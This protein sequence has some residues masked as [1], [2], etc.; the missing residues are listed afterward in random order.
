MKFVTVQ[1]CGF[2]PVSTRRMVPSLPEASMPWS[3]STT[4]R[5]ASAQR[6]VVQLVEHRQQRFD[7]GAT[8][9]LVVQAEAGGRVAPGQAGGFP[10]L[11]LQAVED[12]IWW[13]GHSGTLATSGAG[14]SPP[15]C[16]AA[17]RGRSY[18][19]RVHPRS[20]PCR[21]GP[22]RSPARWPTPAR[23]RRRCAT[24]TRRHA[25]SARTPSRRPRAAC[26]DRRRAPRAP[27]GL[28]P[29]WTRTATAVPGAC[30]R[31]RCPPDC[32]APGAG[33]LRRPRR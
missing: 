15:G 24:A 25:R 23:P 1:P 12:R 33:G 14:P 28:P 27:L 13:R 3:T 17:R 7:P 31:A 29:S 2:S 19:P 10:R 18:R 20:R 9:L 4:L 30:A 21:R 32:R 16:P 8:A 22:P 5:F 11:D 6:P 26:P